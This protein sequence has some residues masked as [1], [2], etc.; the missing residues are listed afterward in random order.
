MRA[1]LIVVGA[2]VLLSALGAGSVHAGGDPYATQ[3]DT[4]PCPTPPSG[5]SNTPAAREVLTPNTISPDGNL[6]LYFSAPVVEIVC[7]YRTAAAKD[8][9]VRVYY[10]LPTDMNPW[11]DFDIGC[12]STHAP[13]ASSIAAKA[14]NPTQRVYRVIG[15]K[16]WS[17]ATFD[18]A[19]KQ[20]KPEDVPRFE[21]MTQE[22]LKG[23]QG[24]AHN[25]SLAGNGHPT[26][27][28]SNWTFSFN[29]R[30]TS[31]GVTSS[32]STSGSFGTTVSPGGTTAGAISNLSASNFP[33]RVTGGGK[34]R[35]LSI[36]VG[37][38][39]AFSHGY[40][41]MLQAHVVVF[42]SNDAGCRK[43]STG[44]LVVS[45]PYLGSPIIKLDVCGH[46]YLHGKGPVTAFIKN[47]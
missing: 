41:A 22:M 1:G 6:I 34:P 28:K 35:V 30:T 44:T 38:P 46:S 21:A 12:T 45:V 18:D 23:V 24:Y 13:A 8:M 37:T 4:V 42:A 7:V 11:N 14:W 2:L 3:A 25:C 47:L 29:A 10:D 20:L 9:D 36:H 33:L 31:G 19:V 26:G 39:I 5:W 32:G 40:G 43:G 15:A 16:T 27:V 17:L